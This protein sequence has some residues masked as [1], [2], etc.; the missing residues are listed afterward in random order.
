MPEKKNRTSIIPR[1]YEIETFR[2]SVNL[3]LWLIMTA[4]VLISLASIFLALIA[5]SRPIPVVVY[6]TEGSPTLFTDT[7]TPRET[8]TDVRIEYFTREFIK[9]W[10]GVDSAAIE[11]DLEESLKMMTPRRRQIIV[12][13]EEGLAKRNS[14]KEKNLKTFFSDWKV[15]IGRYDP[16]DL[17]GKIN[18]ISVGKVIFEPRF[19]KME[20]DDK[21][22]SRYFQSQLV[23]QRVP[24][25]IL[26]IHGMLVDFEQTKFFDSEADLNAYILGES[27]RKTSD[28]AP[29]GVGK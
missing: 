5:F 1:Y 28:A 22:I 3:K 12:N 2:R 20:E 9:N 6:D 25:T 14:Y 19:G 7:R 16:K 23:M 29:G 26:S 11:Q 4:L 13:D 17:G 24:V 21:P 18:V 27:S 15:R 8:L 10:V